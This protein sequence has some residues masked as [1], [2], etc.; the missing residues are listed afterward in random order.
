MK[1][2]YIFMFFAL[3]VVCFLFSK[4][5]A[6][7]NDRFSQI[8]LGDSG[9]TRNVVVMPEIADPGARLLVI[10]VGCT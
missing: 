6:G 10:M 9:D 3:A 5:M 4:A 8:E 7:P 1:R 2:I